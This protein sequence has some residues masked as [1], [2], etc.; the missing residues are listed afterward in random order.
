[1]K[2][3]DVLTSMGAAT[4]AGS[5][6][7]GAGAYSRVEAQRGVT[8]EIVGDEDAY[9]GL[10]YGALDVECGDVVTF[11]TV[12][13]QL[14]QPVKID[15]LGFADVDDVE[16]SDPWFVRCS[17]EEGEQEEFA[18]N[19][20]ELAV[21]QCVEVKVEILDCPVEPVTVE[22]PFDVEVSDEDVLVIAQG[23]GDRSVEITCECPREHGLSFVAFCGD[24]SAGD[25]EE[26][27]VLYDTEEDKLEGVSWS[28]VKGFDGNIE[29]LV[30]YGGFGEFDFDGACD[31]NPDFEGKQ[32]FLNY[33]ENGEDS[34]NYENGED[35]KVEIKP[36]DEEAGSDLKVARDPTQD[37]ETCPDTGQTPSC[38]C[39][40]DTNGSGWE[41]GEG[42]KFEVADDGTL[43]AAEGEE[44]TCK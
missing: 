32:T 35:S 2:R 25:I 24:V 22:V 37:T 39:P 4:A 14:K 38:P 31:E 8:V 19:D 41:T 13:N 29:G 23:S 33:Y 17:D 26:L 6:L 40:D 11:V 28:L 42:V 27:D 43:D 18:K 16:L 15:D 36:D 7:V 5:V 12:T 3:R 1:M 21:G 30:L 10:R 20:D 34:K 9:L 44:F